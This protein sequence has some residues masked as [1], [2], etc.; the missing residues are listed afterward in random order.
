MRGDL[1]KVGWQ[2]LIVTAPDHVFGLGP[3]VGGVG[4]KLNNF[5]RWR[6]LANCILE[7]D[8]FGRFN[9]YGVV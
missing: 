3:G 2:D 5:R 6:S 4:G 8:L 9:G 1:P 7:I